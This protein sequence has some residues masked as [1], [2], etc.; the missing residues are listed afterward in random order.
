MKRLLTL[1]YIFIASAAIVT[2]QDY[3][4]EIIRAELIEVSTQ[5]I[6]PQKEPIDIGI[7]EYVDNILLLYVVSVLTIFI[8]IIW[9][10]LI[11]RLHTLCSQFKELKQTIENHIRFNHNISSTNQQEE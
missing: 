4:E 6:Q 8:G 1:C 2:A 7:F 3:D 11:F 10:I 9:I 5:P